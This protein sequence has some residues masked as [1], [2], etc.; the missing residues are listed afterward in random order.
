MRLPLPQLPRDPL[1]L[2]SGAA[3]RLLLAAGVLAA[4]W[5]AVAWAFAA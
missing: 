1:D 5:A 3:A 2:S 4:L